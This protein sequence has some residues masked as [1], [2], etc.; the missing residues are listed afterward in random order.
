MPSYSMRVNGHFYNRKLKN[1]SSVSRAMPANTGTKL[2]FTISRNPSFTFGSWKFLLYEWMMISVTS[3][4][5]L[6]GNAKRRNLFMCL[7]IVTVTWKRKQRTWTYTKV[8]KSFKLRWF[9]KFAINRAYELAIVRQLR[10]TWTLFSFARATY[11]CLVRMS[12][13]VLSTTTLLP[14]S[15]ASC[16][17]WTHFCHEPSKSRFTCA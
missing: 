10:L 3:L 9:Y 1:R 12:P 15:N 2:I 5:V 17:F 7:A 6:S 4:W 8:I 11:L 14:A 13:F 16:A